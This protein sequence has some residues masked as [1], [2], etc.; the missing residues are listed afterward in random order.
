MKDLES[1]EIKPITDILVVGL[2]GIGSNLVDLVVPALERC[3]INVNL[4]IMDDDIVDHSNLGHQRYSKQEVGQNKAKCLAKRHSKL[5]FVNVVALDEALSNSEQLDQYDVIIVAVDRPEPRELVH[6]MDIDWLDLRCQGDGWIIID[7]ST[8]SKIVD[9][10]PQSKKP[11]SCQMPGA[12]EN[13]NIE[14]GFAAVAVIGAQWLFQKMRL[15]NG[16]NTQLPGFRMGYLT[17]G[18]INPKFTGLMIYD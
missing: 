4:S 5:D 2:G 7:S 15:I 1:N 10:L 11:T 17:H 8:D 18:E 16:A 3:K 6:R 12:I 14:F 9:H 13:G